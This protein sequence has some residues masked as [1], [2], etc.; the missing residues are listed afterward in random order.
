MPT[1]LPL[2]TDFTGASITEAQFKT[3]IT[4]L[5]DYLSGL[6][7]TTGVPTDALGA[8]NALLAATVTKSAAYTVVATDKGK[9]IDCSATLTL[10]L[11]AAA[12]LAAG[13][14]F[15]VRNSGAGTVTLDPNAS[16]LIDG[17]TTITIAP[18]ESFLISCDGSG[19]KT[20]G[21]TGYPISIANGGTGQTTAAAALSALGGV[22]RDQMT[23][24]VGSYC[25]ARSDVIVAMD[26]TVSGANLHA[27]GLYIPSV[28]GSGYS[29]SSGTLSGT[30][31]CC[32]SAAA[33]S[34]STLFQRIA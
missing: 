1:A 10:S 34:M 9:L 11:T 14:N 27:V 4:S 6:L 12:T 20:V 16:E 19:F 5:H 7:G 3:A 22:S 26:G 30:W 2:A 25:F 13:F 18:G 21:R 17:A 29:N 28:S 31:R 15:A 23:T 8:L 24:A 33:A 32:G